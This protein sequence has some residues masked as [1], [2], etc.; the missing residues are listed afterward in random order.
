MFL[1]RNIE[2]SN[3][4]KFYNINMKKLKVRIKELREEN[5]L[6]QTQLAKKL[7]YS[8]TAIAKWESGQRSPDADTIISLALFFNV[9]T[10]FLLGLVDY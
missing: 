3:F 6:T 1:F 8:Q 2:K 7:G 9:S 4:L 10:D 5:S